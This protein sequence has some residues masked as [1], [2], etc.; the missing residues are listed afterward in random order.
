MTGGSFADDAAPTATAQRVV[1][2][3]ASAYFFPRVGDPVFSYQHS[4][5]S[6]RVCTTCHVAHGSNVIM[7]GDYSSTV[8]YPDGTVSAS[9]RLLKVGN[10]GLCTLCHDPSETAL[11]G[12]YTGPTSGS[13]TITTADA[14]TDVFT[15]S[16]AYTLAV[17]DL[18]GIT[19]NTT[20]NGIF[21]V[22]S[23]PTST[24]FTVSTTIGG[25]L[26]NIAT[27]GTG[28]T[29]KGSTLSPIVP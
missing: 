13:W 2:V 20:T 23:T 24:T 6:N 3:T 9:S 29:V 27:N 14:T 10:R 16:A 25:G 11:N 12:T 7:D 8:A 19:G 5:R 21:Y 26:F 28:G 4:T 22:R 17:G 18:I 1:P 15:T